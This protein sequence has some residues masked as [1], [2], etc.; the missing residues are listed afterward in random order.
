MVLG[1]PQ[2]FN[3]FH[4]PAEGVRSAAKGGGPLFDWVGRED[5]FPN[6]TPF[7]E[8]QEAEHIPP[9]LDLKGDRGGG[10]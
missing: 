4:R 9:L 6:T 10:G 5:T 8:P 2:V 7:F 1:G 3:S